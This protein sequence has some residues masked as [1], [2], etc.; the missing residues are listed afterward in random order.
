LNG[1]DGF[2][3]A[4][5]D[6]HE[7][8]AIHQASR[9]GG[10]VVDDGASATTGGPGGRGPGCENSYIGEMWKMQFSNKG[11]SCMCAA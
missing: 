5:G 9:R 8:A 3:L 10:G 4:L 2:V 6:E 7:A 11:S 1:Y